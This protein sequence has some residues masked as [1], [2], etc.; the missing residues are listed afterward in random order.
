MVAVVEEEGF[1]PVYVSIPTFL[2]FSMPDAVIYILVVV[3]Y[4]PVKVESD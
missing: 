4:L 2:S 1:V 3:L